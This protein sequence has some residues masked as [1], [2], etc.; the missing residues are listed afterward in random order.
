MATD[1]QPP[2]RQCTSVRVNDIVIGAD[3]LARRIRPCNAD[4]CSARCCRFG[5]LLDEE[6]FHRV[7]LLIPRLLPMLRPEARAVFRRHGWAF[8]NCIRERYTDPGKLYHASRV[9]KGYCIFLLDDL[10]GGCA[11]HRLAIE[12][13]GPLARYKPREC[14]L[15]PLSDVI[16]GEVRIHRWKGYPC[17]REAADHPLAY[18]QFEDEL[19]LLLGAGGYTELAE[20]V[21]HL[22]EEGTR[23]VPTEFEDPEPISRGRPPIRWT[24]PG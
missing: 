22:Q 2:P 11:L 12:D 23:F 8:K 13:G 19:T 24:R 16:R 14:I 9:A 5:A 18:R 17:T 21:S 1:D 6:E 7:D 20:T 15:F 3:V 10:V 4:V